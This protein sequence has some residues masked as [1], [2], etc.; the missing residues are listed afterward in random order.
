MD[1]PRSESVKSKILGVLPQ[2]LKDAVPS[3]IYLFSL[4][5]YI[6]ILVV[7]PEHPC[8]VG[9]LGASFLIQTAAKLLSV[10]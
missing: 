3:S 8:H 5:F 6:C 2:A 9:T 10:I 7:F 4:P 1:H